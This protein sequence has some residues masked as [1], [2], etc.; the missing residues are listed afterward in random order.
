[1]GSPKSCLWREEKRNKGGAH[2]KQVQKA[3]MQEY[4]TMQWG[5]RNCGIVKQGMDF[6]KRKGSHLQ[7][8]WSLKNDDRYWTVMKE[9][10]PER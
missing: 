3:I 7:V 2:G 10:D 6:G 8:R 5:D 9:N 4:D 1:M